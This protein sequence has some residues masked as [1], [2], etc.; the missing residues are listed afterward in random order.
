M[1]NFF[2]AFLWFLLLALIALLFHYFLGE[3]LCGVCKS[4]KHTNK[5]LLSP[6]STDD[7]NQ[8]LTNFTIADPDGKI[9]FEFP[10]SFI[11]NSGNGD[12]EIPEAMLSFKDSVFDFLNKHQGKELL[13]SAKYLESEG[14]PIGLNRAKFL[15][16]VLTKSGINPNRIL[17]KAVLSDYSYDDSSSNGDGIAMLFRNASEETSKLVED[18]IMNKTLYSKFGSDEFKPDRTLQGYAYELKYYLEKY[19]TKNAMITGY[20]DNVGEAASNH[21]LGLSRAN[22][23]LDFLISEGIEANKLKAS[24]KGELEPIATNDTE[25][26]RAKNRRITIIVD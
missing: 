9:L 7:V 21:T 11:I 18:S 25:E 6:V 19:P 22:K 23:V 24:S 2:K 10:T 1:K 12:V 8:K 16:N 17:P 20:T 4:K 26:G 3:K 15:K 13:I 5:E 14:E